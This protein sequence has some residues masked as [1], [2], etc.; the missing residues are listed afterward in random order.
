MQLLIAEENED[1]TEYDYQKALAVLPFVEDPEDVKHKIWCSAILR[2]KWDSYN[3]NSPQDTIQQLMFFKL[4]DLC[5][6]VGKLFDSYRSTESTSQASISSAAP[7]MEEF[8]PPMDE[9]VRAPEIGP[10]AA[11]RP[12]QFLLK[13]GYEHIHETLRKN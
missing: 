10:L 13:L 3:I 9:I 7:E 2:D 6:F 1:A 4:V 5:F 8:L 12:F 11:S